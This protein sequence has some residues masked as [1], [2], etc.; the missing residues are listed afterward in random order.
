MGVLDVTINYVEG[1]D[2]GW[3]DWVEEVELEDPAG[4]YPVTVEMKPAEA[5]VKKP[6]Q[7][8]VPREMKLKIETSYPYHMPLCH[9]LAMTLG[10]ERFKKLLM[11]ENVRSEEQLERRYL[12]RM[13]REPGVCKNPRLKQFQAFDV[14]K[15]DEGALQRLI[16]GWERGPE[17]V[18]ITEGGRTQ[19]FVTLLAMGPLSPHIINPVKNKDQAKQDKETGQSKGA[20][21]EVNIYLTK[22]P[23]KRVFSGARASVWTR[24]PNTEDQGSQ[25]EEEAEEGEEDNDGEEVSTAGEGDEEEREAEQARGQEGGGKAAQGRWRWR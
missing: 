12:E 1:G 23:F 19:L 15:L 10:Q 20:E 13:M 16:R 18:T 22:N 17:V 4:W 11:E 14:E 6:A 25:G 9:Y 8:V 21:A 7:A 2:G 24:S 3:I 5:V